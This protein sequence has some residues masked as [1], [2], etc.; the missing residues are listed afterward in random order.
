MDIDG[1][2][3]SARD[4]DREIERER[5]CRMPGLRL[6][7]SSKFCGATLCRDAP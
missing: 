4:R 5:E 1:Q 2:T 7:E 3:Q 6:R